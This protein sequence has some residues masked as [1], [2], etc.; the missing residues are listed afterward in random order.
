[1]KENKIIYEELGECLIE[2]KPIVGVKQVLV[3]MLFMSLISVLLWKLQESSG[4]S[5][6]KL[7]IK[8]PEEIS[9]TIMTMGMLFISIFPMLVDRTGIRIM[10]ISYKS[11]FFKGVVWKWLNYPNVVAIML[12]MMGSDIF[13]GFLENEPLALGIQMVALM[14]VF[15]LSCW[16]C[17]LSLIATV[18]CSRIYYKIKKTLKRETNLKKGTLAELLLEKIARKSEKKSQKEEKHHSYI[19]EEIGCLFYLAI[20]VKKYVT[21]DEL[22]KNVL[23]EIKEI[24]KSDDRDKK[25][26]M[27]N[28][29]EKAQKEYKGQKEFED[30]L[31]ELDALMKEEIS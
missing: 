2:K 25:Y 13:A 29:K 24:I 31:N 1:M 23:I 14:N 16:L 19:Y 30:C 7:H 28:I 8:K 10:G 3:Y 9:G 5:W 27:H 4:C 21:D 18:K 15:G 17:Y 22:L 6:Y 26:L 20:F 12:L 11:Y